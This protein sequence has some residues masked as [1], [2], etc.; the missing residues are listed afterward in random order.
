MSPAYSIGTPQSRH[1]TSYYPGNNQRLLPFLL[2]AVLGY[3]IELEDFYLT[4]WDSTSNGRAF[5]LTTAALLARLTAVEEP[6]SSIRP[7][8]DG[9]GIGWDAEDLPITNDV[10]IKLGPKKSALRTLWNFLAK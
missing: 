4:P 5:M 3:R 10:S 6:A 8:T 7:P 2:S 9:G 1:W